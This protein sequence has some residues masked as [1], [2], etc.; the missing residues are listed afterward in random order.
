MIFFLLLQALVVAVSMIFAPFPVVTE[1]PWGVDSV[2]SQGVAYF[3]AFFDFFPPFS[4]LF[5]ATL[6]YIGF[7]LGIIVLRLFLGSRTP[8]HV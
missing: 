5:T 6:I 4:T 7:R 3:K 8:T 1:L 2:F